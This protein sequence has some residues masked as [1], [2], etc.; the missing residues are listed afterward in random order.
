MSWSGGYRIFERV[1][2]AIE[3]REEVEISSVDLM[4]ELIAALKAEIWDPTE[5]GVGGLEEDSIIR[6]AMAR[7]GNVEKCGSE[8]DINPWQCEGNAGHWPTTQHQD[9]EGNTWTEEESAK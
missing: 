7:H 1:S 8:H 4:S 2:Q 9:Y 3:K 6:E 5:Y